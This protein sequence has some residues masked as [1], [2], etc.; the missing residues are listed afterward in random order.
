MPGVRHSR[1][2]RLWVAKPD[3]LREEHHG[4]HADGTL[5]VQ[6][7]PTWWSYSP[8]MGAMTNNGDE[9]QQHGIG[10]MF[11]PLLDPARVMGLFDIEITGRG[12]RAGHSVICALWRPRALSH[13]DQFALH[14]LGTGADEHTVEIDAGRGVLL[15]L[16]ARFEGAPMAICEALDVTFDDDLDDELFRF[17]APDGEEPQTPASLHGFHRGVALHEAAALVPFELHALAD[18]PAGWQLTVSVQ[19]AS[20]RPPMPAAVHLHYRS[21]DATAAL[22][23]ALGSA[24]ARQQ[25]RLDDAE[26][27][28]RGDRAMR[29]RRRT[30][31][32]SQ[33]QL[34]TVL[35]DTMVMMSSD[36]LS[37]DDLVE[38]TDRLRP[39]SDRPPSL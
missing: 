8:H 27:V 29:I 22:N 25:W 21:A 20:Q 13:H 3:R 1:G 38:L 14:Q 28:M 16:E 2:A 37:A 23:I 31:A 18:A 11:Q 35:G 24:G 32:W 19:R 10:Q 39:A 15:R 26:E 4:G 12:E 7:G 5:A 34:L 36:N 33:A 30:E 9:R 17:V 6:A